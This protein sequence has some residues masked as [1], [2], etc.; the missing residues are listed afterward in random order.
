MFVGNQ[1]R[2]IS[3]FLC[4]R[5]ATSCWSVLD[6]VSSVPLGVAGL[7][8][9]LPQDESLLIEALFVELGGHRVHQAP[10]HAQEDHLTRSEIEIKYEF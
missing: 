4:M 7:L 5:V 2:N 9:S 8:L 6:D 1:V 10:R 3:I